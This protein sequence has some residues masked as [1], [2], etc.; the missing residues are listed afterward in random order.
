MSSKWPEYSNI[1]LFL[2]IM[3]VM[4]S[5]QEPQVKVKRLPP[6]LTLSFGLP[7]ILL[8]KYRSLI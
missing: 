3:A 7:S 8:L 4:T 2:V 6:P 1:V 5:G